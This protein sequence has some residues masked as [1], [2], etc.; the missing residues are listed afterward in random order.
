MPIVDVSLALPD[1]VEA[2]L[3]LVGCLEGEVP[4][5]ACLPT[6]AAAAA[7]RLAARPGWSGRDGQLA[8]TELAGGPVSRLVL[9]GM[10]KREQLHVRRLERWLRAAAEHASLQG[11]RRLAVALPSH[12]LTLGPAATGRLARQLATARYRFDRFREKPK[13]GESLVA[14]T[15]LVPAVDEAQAREVAVAVEVAR[16][17]ELTR[18]LGNTPP[19]VASP[20][21]IAERAE[22]MAAELGLEVE[23]LTSEDLERKG[24]GGMLAVGGGS[25]NPPRLVRLT[26]HGAESPRVAL[27]G[28][29]VTFDTGGISIKPAQDMDEMKWDKM[30]ACTVLGLLQTVAR[31]RLPLELSV[32]TPLAENMP[33]G[34]SYRPGDILRCYNGKTVEVLNTDAEG[35]IILADAIAWAAESSPNYLLEYST[36]TGACVVALGTSGGGLYSPSDGLSGGLLAAA[37]EA[38]ERLWRMPL[39]PEFREAIEGTHADLKNVAGRWGGANTA[40][41]FLSHFVGD[42]EQWAHLDIAGPAYVGEK[43]DG[44]RGATGYGIALTVGWLRS[45]VAE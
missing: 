18:D 28:K 2:D 36:L 32:Y 21:W 15:L 9:R 25:R 31:L 38:G 19:N 16:G 39:W 37:Q 6:A 35:R 34:A 11:V 4:D 22:A 23:V 41:A 8:E 45:L 40:A 5:A 30:G 7:A 3:L 44:P 27:V 33:D 24:M 1:A 14:V 17:M 13:E 42:V 29:G 12:P 20:E 10:G 43:G 26:W